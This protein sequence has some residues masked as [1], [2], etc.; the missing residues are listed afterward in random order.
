MLRHRNEFPVEAKDCG[1]TRVQ[2]LN[3]AHV[4]G[5]ANSIADYQRMYQLSR[6]NAP[7]GERLFEFLD[8]GVEAFVFAFA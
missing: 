1:A 6:H 8:R 5:N 2:S 4:D 7:I 3:R